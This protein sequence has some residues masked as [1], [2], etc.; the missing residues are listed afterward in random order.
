MN[1]PNN[2]DEQTVQSF[3]DEWKKHN[4]SNISDEE[5][6]SLF[7]NYFSLIKLEDFNKTTEAF[8]MGCG[9]GRWANFLAPYVGKLNCIDPSDAIEVSKINLSH[10][11][12]IQFIKGYVDNCGLKKNS[13]DFGYSLGVLHHI[14]NTKKALTTCVSYL[15]PGAPFLVYLYYNFENR[16]IFFKLIWSLTDQIR[17]IISM[18]PS[19]LKNHVT[20]FIA[21]MVYMP[22]SRLAK[23][24]EILGLPYSW[25]PLSFYRNSSFK[26]LITDSRDRFGTP[27][28]QRFSKLEIESMM[29][30]AGLENITF[31]HNEPFWVSVGYKKI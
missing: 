4:Q 16:S 29:S 18:L 5:L 6:R 25:L 21:L 9:S 20:N 13:Q 30:D 26:T 31:S 17:K 22:L 8:D 2:F 15:K 14:P 10:H 23:F 28:E 3:G 1:P 12:N 24:I 27:L 7:Q 11:K 19:R